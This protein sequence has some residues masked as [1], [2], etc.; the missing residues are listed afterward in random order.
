MRGTAGGSSSLAFFVLFS[1]RTSSTVSR[2]S[3]LVICPCNVL[4][5]LPDSKQ[6]GIPSTSDSP[7]CSHNPP[8]FSRQVD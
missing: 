7:G 4:L 2:R 5:L 1:L 8:N 6:V 3:A